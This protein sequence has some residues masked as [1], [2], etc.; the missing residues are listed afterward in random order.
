M[1]S[2]DRDMAPGV[3]KSFKKIYKENIIKFLESNELTL[4]ND[5]FNKEYLYTE[6]FYPVLNIDKYNKFA[7][8]E[9]EQLK[10]LFSC[11]TNVDK[12]LDNKI[13]KSQELAYKFSKREV[14]KKTYQAMEG[15][16]HN[17]NTMNSRAGAQCPFS[18]LNFG[19]DTSE[20]GR[21]VIEQFL[22]ATEAGLGNGETPIF[23]Y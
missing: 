21:L 20:E 3:A 4:D 14:T 1:N 23:P 17:L 16:I 5:K 10:N 15:L 12:D 13:K 6:E 9:F 11:T 7:V 18:S 19:T 8:S 2:F 22:L